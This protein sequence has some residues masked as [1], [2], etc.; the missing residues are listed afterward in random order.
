MFRGSEGGLEEMVREV[1]RSRH[2]LEG[3]GE[4]CSQ[5]GVVSTKQHSRGAGELETKM[6][7]I[8]DTCQ[9]S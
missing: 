3:R 4:E 5:E 7:G 8:E 9:H 6:G 1:G 2:H